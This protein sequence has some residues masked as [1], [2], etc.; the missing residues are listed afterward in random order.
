LNLTLLY[1]YPNRI[2]NE[3]DGVYYSTIAYLFRDLSKFFEK[4]YLM[5]PVADFRTEQLRRFDETPQLEVIKTKSYQN[6]FL[7]VAQKYFWSFQSAPKFKE[8]QYRADVVVLNIPSALTCLAYLP[9]INKPLVVR[10]V[11]DEQEVSRVSTSLRCKI[12]CSSRFLKL[13][14]LAEQ[15]LLRKANAIICRN[16]KFKDKIVKKYGLSRSKISVIVPAINTDIFK[17]LDLNYR[18]KIKENLG[19]KANQLVVGFVSMYISRAKGAVTLLKAFSRLHNES[20]Q[21]RLLLIGKDKLGLKGN[22]SIICCGLVN[23]NEL[24]Y[25]YNAMD[26]LVF[27]SRS[28]GAPKVVME[29]F[30]CGIP[31]VASNVGAISDWIKDGENGFL[32]G[33]GDVN[34]I[35]D[36]CRK[37]LE[38]EELRTKIGKA[39]RKYAVQNFDHIELTKKNVDVIKG[40]MPEK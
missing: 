17:P 15:Y 28:E 35:V 13:R 31:V 8:Y 25:Y 5:A 3:N 21:V 7:W 22:P 2:F 10:V 19:L 30:A 24:P 6:R 40:I 38:S 36:C 1:C 32:I 16:D 12:E 27:P 18:Q 9:L 23:K 11:G 20:P 4:M 37:L 26:I 29:A 14:E 39:A 34:E 33:P